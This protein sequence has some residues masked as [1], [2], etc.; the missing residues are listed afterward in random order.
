[1]S[2]NEKWK[3]QAGT[4]ENHKKCSQ[5]VSVLNLEW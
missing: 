1:M 2:D 4:K 3:T 5:S